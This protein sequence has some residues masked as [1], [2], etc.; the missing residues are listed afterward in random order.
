MAVFVNRR[1]LGQEGSIGSTRLA[2]ASASI[3]LWG[4]LDKT[5][6]FPNLMDDVESDSTSTAS[7]ANNS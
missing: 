1:I 4:L 3:G 5:Q 6:N 2:F 7:A